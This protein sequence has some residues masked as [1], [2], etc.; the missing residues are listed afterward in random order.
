MSTGSR[1]QKENNTSFLKNVLMLMVS[2]VLVK[3]LGLVYRILIVDAEGFGNVGNGYY[4]TGYQIYMV[5]LA[6]SSTGIPNVISKLVSERVARGDYIA[7]RRVFKVS[8]AIFVSFGA[9][10]GILLFAGADVIS[11][12]LLRASGVKYT[13][14]V[15]APAICLVSASAVMRGY[16]AGMGSMKANSTSQ[17]IEQFF[18]CLLSIAFVYACVGQDTAVMAAAGNLSTTCACLVAVIYLIVYYRTRKGDIDAE[19]AAQ[20]VPTEDIPLKR[21]AIVIF[22]VSIPLSISSLISTANSTIDTV[23]VSRCIQKVF[24]SSIPDAAVLEET[25]MKLYGILQKAETITHLPLAVSATLYTTMVP[26]VSSAFAKNDMDAVNRK[27]SSSVMISSLIIYPCMGGLAVLAGPILKMLYPSAPEGA[28]ILQ[29]LVLILPLCSLTQIIN[30]VLYGVGKL[31]VPATAL[32]IGSALKLVLNI[33]LI[34]IPSLNI[35]GAVISTI[36]YQLTVFII[37]VIVVYRTVKIRIDYV[38]TFLKPMLSSAVMSLAVWGVY[39]LISLVAGNTLSTLV[40]VFAGVAV[41][42]VALFL[43]KTFTKEDI[44]ELP[45]GKRIAG[46]LARIGVLR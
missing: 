38:K 40:S 45:M 21:L 37:E 27:I 1:L 31:A 5:L 33:L 10:L 2:S 15:L 20:T 17:V 18:N 32:G 42:V 29:L 19:C 4:A 28:L 43:F 6:I 8:L 16:F 35:Y 11:T 3:V 26:A 34:S 39:S 24:A 9:L 13:L 23:T 46:I 30:G 41:Y 22:S 12:V 36:V 14:M 25:A 44:E 7:A